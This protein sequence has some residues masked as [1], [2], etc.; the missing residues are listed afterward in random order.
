MCEVTLRRP[1]CAPADAAILQSKLRAVGLGAVQARVA[2]PAPP[3]PACTLVPQ[4]ARAQSLGALWM[5]GLTDTVPASAP[6]LSPQ[7]VS[8]LSLTGS[9]GQSYLGVDHAEVVRRRPHN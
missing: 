6:A 5:K 3:S 2:P 7:V 9:D 8:L 4:P 1:A